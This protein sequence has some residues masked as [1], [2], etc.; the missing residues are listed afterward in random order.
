MT[1]RAGV[2]PAHGRF[3]VRVLDA[4]VYPDLPEWLVVGCAVLVCAAILS[5]Y[6]RRY[7]RRT[8]YGQ[9]CRKSGIVSRLLK[10]YDHAERAIQRALAIAEEGSMTTVSI[11]GQWKTLRCSGKLN[12]E[13]EMLQ[14]HTEERSPNLKDFW[15][16]IVRNSRGSLPS[17]WILSE[18]WGFGSRRKGHRTGH[19][20]HGRNREAFRLRK[21]RLPRNTRFGIG[22]GWA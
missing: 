22:G 15:L 16:S 19:L 21:I 12:P 18:S 8:A 6:L 7:H 17:E 14:R 1:T 9:W 4:V 3:L 5:V 13:M 10:K 11:L 2:E 20:S